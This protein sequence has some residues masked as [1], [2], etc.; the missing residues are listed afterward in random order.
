VPVDIVA[1][2]QVGGFAQSRDG[3]VVVFDRSSTMHPPALFACRADG[4]G[5]RSIES[6]NRALLA[7]HALGKARPFTIKGWG[8][9]PVQM[10]AIYPPNFDPKKKWPLLHAIHGGP[11]AAHLDSWHFRWNAQVFAGQGYVV[12]GVNYHGSSGFGQ[13]WLESI[14]GR[15]GVKEYADI[16]AGTDYLLRQGLYRSPT[17]R[18]YRRQLWRFPGRLHERAHQPL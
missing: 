12:V 7:R 8:G 18:G 3:S 4:A 1:G 10:W 17:A 5:E 15:Y 14:T 6:V 13:K 16:E 2:G 11:H 9:Q